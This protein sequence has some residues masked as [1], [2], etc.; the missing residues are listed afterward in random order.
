[1]ARTK[2]F[3]ELRPNSLVIWYCN[4]E[5]YLHAPGT[6]LG[7]VCL[8]TTYYYGDRC[9]F[10]RKRLTMIFQV[11]LTGSFNRLS[12][13][14]RC[15]ILLVRQNTTT[16]ILSH[17]AFL[18]NPLQYCLPKYIAHLIYPIHDTLSPSS[19]DSVH[20]HA[21]RRSTLEHRESWRFPVPFPFLPVSRITKRHDMNTDRYICLC[22]L[23]RI[24]Y[25]CL[26]AFQLWPM[27]SER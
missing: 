16:H 8:C 18:F 4:R 7:F 3:C 27:Y 15:V 13:S 25:R 26:I 17:G 5:L 14:L 21:F 20:I 12:P 22:A 6:R 11:Q 24:S 19:N 1:M 23:D 10:Q 9:Q 2:C